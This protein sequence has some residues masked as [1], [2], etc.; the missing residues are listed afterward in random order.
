MEKNKVR[1]GL[2]NAYYAKATFDDDGNVSYGTP[3]RLPGAVS[4]AVSAQGGNENFYADDIVYYIMSNNSGYDGTLELALIPE[5]FLTE[6]LHEIKN[7]DGVLLENADI[8]P[9]R[10]ALLFE[11]TGDR[12]AIRHVLY[13]CSATR[14]SVEGDTKEENKQVKTETLNLSATPLPNGYVKAK[15]SQTTS[16]AVYDAWYQSV[17]K[18]NPDDTTKALLDRLTLGSLTLS[19]AFDPDTTEYTVTTSNTTN[20]ITAAGADGTTVDIKVNGSAHTSGEGAT[21]ED[22]ENTV[23]ITVIQEGLTTTVYTVTVTKTA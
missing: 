21:W 4:L 1:F 2:K 3:K 10:F 14:P 11:F 7:S 8:E 16:K 19:P 17:Y 22:G 12:H 13:C 9:E 20:V 18:P 6:I 15:T 5:D 23:V